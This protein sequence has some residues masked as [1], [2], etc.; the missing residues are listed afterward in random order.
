M[1]KYEL[2]DSDDNLEKLAAQLEKIQDSDIEL[3]DVNDTSDQRPKAQVAKSPQQVMPIVFA[4]VV[5]VIILVALG[6]FLMSRSGMGASLVA[7]PNVV[8]QP[9]PAARRVMDDTRLK[10]TLLYDSSSTLPAGTVISSD[11]ASATRVPMGSSVSVVV[12]GAAPAIPAAPV[13]ITPPNSGKTGSAGS[14]STVTNSSTTT[15]TTPPTSGM[16]TIPDVKNLTVD[17]ARQ[18]LGSL[19]LRVMTIKGENKQLPND[20]VLASNPA[21]GEEVRLGA[22]VEITINTLT[23]STST[24]SPP[25][26]PVKISLKDYVNQSGAVV[27]E[28]LKKLGL[29]AEPRIISTNLTISG[30]VIS[31][32]P[33]AGKLVLPGDVITVTVAK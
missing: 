24:S 17:N 3:V 21:A 33:P 2:D 26:A 13:T 6:L 27:I 20:V 23:G 8:G 11:P 32:D 4:G 28:E 12:A 19:G 5:G 9:L 15:T 16:R 25:A 31:T 22:E 10:L 7:V 29:K 30:N 1:A 14:T 18:I